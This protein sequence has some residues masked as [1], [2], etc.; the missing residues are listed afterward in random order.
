MKKRMSSIGTIIFLTIFVVS[1]RAQSA[2]TPDI[3]MLTEPAEIDEPAIGLS[4][5]TFVNME[6]ISPQTGQTIQLVDGVYSNGDVDGGILAAGLLPQAAF[7]DLTG[8]G[9]DDA[10]LL[11][12]E[13]MGGSG[14]FVSL[15]AMVN[16]GNG[17]SQAGSYLVDDRPLIN[18]ISINNNR[19]VMDAVIHNVNDSMAEPTM[20]VVEELSVSDH[21]FILRRLDSTI[22]DA[23]RTIVI[24]SPVDGED[25]DATVHVKG[26]M[27]IAA[28]ENT[29]VYKIFD[30]SNNVIDQGPFMVSAADMGAP[31]T[32]D[33]TLVIPGA[34]SGMCYRIVLEETSM[35]DGSTLCLNSVEVVMK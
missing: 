20:K 34:V 29:L 7:G 25:V 22:S 8:D 9:L 11:V 6:L 21:L 31:A 19:I 23:E 14:V 5:D 3:P 26:S 35:A 2:A 13:N 32:F 18:A 10:V 1:C 24:D 15:V 27:P 17:F 30:S 33:N 4:L 16:T 12:S 28:F